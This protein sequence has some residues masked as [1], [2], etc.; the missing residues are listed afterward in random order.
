MI[1]V[2]I[3]QNTKQ[4]TN[5]LKGIAKQIPF[6]TSL[7]INKTAQKVKLKEEKEIVDVFDRPTSF[8]KNSLFIK[9][10]NKNNLTALVKLKDFSFK[11]TSAAKYLQAQIAGGER[12]LKR[13]ELALRSAGILPS[14][15]F[16]V[17]GQAANIDQYGNIARSQI[18]QL[19]AYF[20]ANRDVG[21]TSN[22][23]EKTRGKLAKSTNKRYGVS[24]FVMPKESGMQEGIYQRIHSNFGKAIR[25]VLI[26]VDRARY[27]AIY[28]FKFVAEKV[29]K[30]EYDN[31]FRLALED[32]IRTAK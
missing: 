23:T 19:L 32:A 6:A 10:S 3:K 22:S 5:K 30:K 4:I 15:Y 13:Y 2:S 11:G 26:F 16:T 12:R 31:E 7:A 20:R 1:S 18:V 8:T 24:Y 28:D 25:P 27:E 9:P 21:T 17:P 29:I 14:G